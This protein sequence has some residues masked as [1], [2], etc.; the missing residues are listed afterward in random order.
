MYSRPLC[1]GSAVK[2]RSEITRSEAMLVAHRRD[3]EQGLMEGRKRVDVQR[4]SSIAAVRF[5]S[6]FSATINGQVDLL[7]GNLTLLSF[8]PALW[9][10]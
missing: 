1:T 3:L 10:K 8:E 4:E 5:E 6:Y 9:G 2:S 7:A